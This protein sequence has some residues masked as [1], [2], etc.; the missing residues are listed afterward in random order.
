M[1]RKNKSK[2]DRSKQIISILSGFMIVATS[3]ISLL[4]I[5]TL[6]LPDVKAA[7]E[8]QIE[9]QA[10]QDLSLYYKSKTG[11]ADEYRVF[12]KF[13]ISS[14]PHNVTKTTLNWVKLKIY[15]R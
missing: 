13:D 10:V 1:E 6:V 3:F 5:V 14:I 4:S 15:C 11:I 8:Q 12:L 2:V 9:I 7:T